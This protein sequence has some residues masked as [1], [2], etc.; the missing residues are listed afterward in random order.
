[1]TS[2]INRLTHTFRNMNS[3]GFD[4]AGYLKWGFFFV[5]TN[6]EHLLAVFEELQGSGYNLG[7]IGEREGGLWQLYV[8]KIDIL[9]PEKLHKRN[10]AFNELAQYCS[11]QLY[12]GWDVERIEAN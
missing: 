4:T 12:D 1:M 3:D 2:D 7:S 6:K 11:V 8:T 5:D 10:L 9:T